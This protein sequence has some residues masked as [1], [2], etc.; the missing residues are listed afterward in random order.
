MAP[1]LHPLGH[2]ARTLP[3]PENIFLT[4][5]WIHVRERLSLVQCQKK[6]PT[7]GNR[8]SYPSDTVPPLIIVFFFRVAKL[9]L[10]SE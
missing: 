1:R 2:R 3:H 6:L 4:E 5:G 10:G 7:S 8:Y 9:K